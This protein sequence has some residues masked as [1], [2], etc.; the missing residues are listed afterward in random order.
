MLQPITQAQQIIIPDHT[1][2]TNLQIAGTFHHK[3][4]MLI[5]HH[6]FCNNVRQWLL[7]S[8]SF[9]SRAKEASDN[10]FWR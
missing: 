1:R 4:A 10:G 2:A 7:F 8:F 3:F 9:T 5:S 6:G